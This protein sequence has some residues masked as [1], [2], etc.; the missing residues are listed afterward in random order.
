M[1]DTVFTVP[2]ALLPERIANLFQSCGFEPVGGL[3]DAPDWVADRGWDA[4]RIDSTDGHG[5]M[6][7]ARLTPDDDR[8]T[9]MHCWLNAVEESRLEFGTSQLGLRLAAQ[10]MLVRA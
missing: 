1:A 2:P 10:V 7:V 8:L 6:V 9:V 4:V 3:S 5:H